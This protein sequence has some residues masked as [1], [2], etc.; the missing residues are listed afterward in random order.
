MPFLRQHTACGKCS[1]ASSKHVRL[2]FVYVT[3][4]SELT[5][6]AC[7]VLVFS[8]LPLLVLLLLLL[9]LLCLLLLCLLL[10]RAHPPLCRC[11]SNC[12]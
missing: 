2:K 7:A 6:C 10:C 11:C 1:T 3:C 8:T 4:A 5:N 12:G 9:L